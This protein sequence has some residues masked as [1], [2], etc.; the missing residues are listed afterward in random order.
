MPHANAAP[1]P[2]HRLMVARHVVEDGCYV[3]EPMRYGNLL[4]AG[5]R[6]HRSA[7]RREAPQPRSGRRQG[8]ERGPPTRGRGVRRLG[9]VDV[10]RTRLVV[11]KSYAVEPLKATSIAPPIG[12]TAS[13]R[14]LANVVTTPVLGSTRETLPATSSVTY[15]APPGPTALPEARRVDPRLRDADAIAVMSARC[16]GRGLSLD[17]HKARPVVIAVTVLLCVPYLWR[18]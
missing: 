13:G 11:T 12:A 17:V 8:P 7:D 5:R 4:L 3:C 18:G 10:H 15:S 2:G 1:T 16:F 14:P 9:T 6:P